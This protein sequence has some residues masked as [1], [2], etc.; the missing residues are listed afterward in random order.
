ATREWKLDYY[1][2]QYAEGKLSVARAAR[3]AGVSIWEMMECLRRK[4][5][6]L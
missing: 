5:M 6:L 4:K 3:E 2:R 1:A